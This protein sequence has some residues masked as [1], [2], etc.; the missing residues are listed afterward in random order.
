MGNT[1]V[2]GLRE[3]PSS[4]VGGKVGGGGMRLQSQQRQKEAGEFKASLVYKESPR[5]PGLIHRELLSGRT[6]GGAEV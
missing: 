2:W 4:R 6:R 5:Q 1:G 3:F